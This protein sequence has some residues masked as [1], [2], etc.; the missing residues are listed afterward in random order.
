MKSYQ[1]SPCAGSGARSEPVARRLRCKDRNRRFDRN[2]IHRDGSDENLLPT[3][4]SKGTITVAASP[5][6][7]AEI[8]AQVAPILAAE[9]W[10]LEVKEFQ[11]TC[12]AEQRRRE[13]RV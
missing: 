12:A 5:T 11:D 3:L 9:G 1:K 6:P 2:G 4:S 8:L 10:T 13:R 7:H